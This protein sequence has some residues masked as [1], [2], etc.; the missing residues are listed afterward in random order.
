MSFAKNDLA[1]AEWTKDAVAALINEYAK[2]KHLY[3]PK[4]SK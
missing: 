2:H 3:D 4:S 1:A